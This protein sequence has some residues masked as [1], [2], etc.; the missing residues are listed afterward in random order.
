MPARA[1][2]RH[3]PLLGVLLI[4]AM[5]AAFAAL[6]TAVRW[7]GATMPVLLLLACRYGAQAFLMGVWLAFDRRRRLRPAHPRFQALR[8]SLLLASSGFAFF[9][10]QHLP[11]AEFTAINML[12]PVLVTFLAAWLLKERVSALRWTLV[13]LSFTGALVIIRPGS[14]LFGWAVL[15]PLGCA[16]TYASF[17]VLTSRLSALEDPLVTHFWTGVVGAA[18]VLPVLALSPVDVTA[19]LAA[20]TPRQWAVLAA[21][22]LF[23]TGG[24][25]LLILAFRVASAATLMPFV[26]TQIASAT[27]TGW[28]VFGN[29]PDAFGWA[30]MAIIAVSGAATAW[31]NVRAAGRQRAPV[32]VV[33]ADSMAD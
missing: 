16:C 19:A 31:L 7:A 6:D 4:V 15:F 11:V 21:I 33:A 25:L 22:G 14:G 9:G 3:R 17:Q 10:L 13:A 5:G 26:Y 23:G 20:A 12:A 30:G 24:H 2:A 1:V 27:L 8:G 18:L 32:S 29:L 28:W